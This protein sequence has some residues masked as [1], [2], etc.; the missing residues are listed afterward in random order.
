M[1]EKSENNNKVIMEDEKF[2]CLRRRL[3]D[4]ICSK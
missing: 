4:Q 1:L 2:Y 3:H